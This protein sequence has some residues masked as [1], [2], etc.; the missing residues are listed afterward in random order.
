MKSI[1]L[2]KNIFNFKIDR[3]K[4]PFFTSLNVLE[5]LKKTEND[6]DLNEINKGLSEIFNIPINV[7]SDD[8]K[9]SFLSKF[10]FTDGKFN[11][12]IKYKRSLIDL[13]ILLFFIIWYKIFSKK[14]YVENNKDIFFDELDNIDHLKYCRKLNENFKNNSIFLIKKFNYK[15]QN[16]KFK[17]ITFRKFCIYNSNT[18]KNNFFKF[19]KIIFQIYLK[20]KK[21]RINLFVIY[22]YLI[23]RIFKYDKIFSQNKAKYYFSYK[24]YNTSSIKNFIFKKKGGL[25]ISYFQKNLA[26]LSISFLIKTD[27]LFSLGMGTSENLKLLGSEIKEIVP[28]GSLILETNI[29]N[30][31]HKK[32]EEIDILNIGINWAHRNHTSNLDN[33]ID[34]N[35]YE[36]IRW[37]KKISI[38]FPNL[39]IFIKHH[40]NYRGDSKEIEILK[41]TKIKLISSDKIKNT[42]QYLS[43]SKIITSFGST[44]ILE[45]RSLN[46]NSF[47][48][49]PDGM[50][51]SYF[52]L[53]KNDKDL[54]ITSYE[55]FENVIEEKFEKLIDM[56]VGSNR[57]FNKDDFCLE[58]SIVSERIYNY[59]ISN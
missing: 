45:S 46:K 16:K 5:Y 3:D 39:K 59:L 53:L 36:H 55:Q 50:N 38:K 51:Q 48:L 35:Y 9:K 22:N 28:V 24:F 30:L 6:E 21:N 10:N 27:I 47:F 18:L 20:S 57:K 2:I 19:C 54:R 29:D 34:D 42:Y 37:L 14:L 12:K 1:N 40:S 32:K 56:T 44:M 23:F 26:E 4:E 41:G 17:I 25:K 49:D 7:I 11:Q 33:K 31:N 8:L 15:K 58:S 43:N 13:G 52:K